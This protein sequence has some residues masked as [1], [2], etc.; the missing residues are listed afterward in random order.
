MTAI[1]RSQL[2]AQ[3]L[4]SNISIAYEDDMDMKPVFTPI[5]LARGARGHGGNNPRSTYHP[6]ALST[7]FPNSTLLTPAQLEDQGLIFG[8]FGFCRFLYWH[9]SNFY[10]KG[11]NIFGTIKTLINIT[12][13]KFTDSFIKLGITM[14]NK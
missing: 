13:L 6:S 8:K 14:S 9:L 7:G 4:K 3:E 10:H 12:G 1:P 11:R 2:S 5:K